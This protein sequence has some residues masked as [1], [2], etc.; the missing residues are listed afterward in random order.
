[1]SIPFLKKIAPLCIM[2]HNRSKKTESK[3]KR[4]ADHDKNGTNQRDEF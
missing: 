2:G 1:M 4:R 3:H